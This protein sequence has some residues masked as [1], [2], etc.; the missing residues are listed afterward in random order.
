MTKQPCPVCSTPTHFDVCRKCVQEY[1]E[2]ELGD[3]IDALDCELAGYDSVPGEELVSDCDDETWQAQ[4]Y[5]EACNG[6]TT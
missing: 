2:R 5:R 6:V 3:H 4:T 1:V